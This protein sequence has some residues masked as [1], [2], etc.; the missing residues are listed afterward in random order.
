MKLRIR[1]GDQIKIPLYYQQARDYPIDLYFL[2]DLS[3]SMADDKDK[4]SALGDKVAL[5]MKN[6]TN[7]FRVGFGSFVDK[8][9]LPFVNTVPSK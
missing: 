8:P 2:M 4:L 7:N 1:N 9:D 5:V 6:I 3:N